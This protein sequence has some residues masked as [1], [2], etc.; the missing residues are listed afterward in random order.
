VGREDNRARRTVDAH[1]HAQDVQGVPRGD[2]C[3][4]AAEVI[5]EPTSR[6]FDAVSDS[7]ADIESQHDSSVSVPRESGGSVSNE[8]TAARNADAAD[9]PNA[10]HNAPGADPSRSVEDSPG[11]DDTHIAE[12]ARRNAD[13]GGGIGSLTNLADRHLGDFRLLRRIGHGGMAEVYLAEQVSLKRNVAVKVL[14][15]EMLADAVHVKRFEQEAKAAGGLNHPNIVQVYT[16]GK[17]GGIHYIAQEYVQGM[18]LREYLNRN[19][20]PDLE[21]ALSFMRQMTSALEAASEAGIVHRDIKPENILI[22][23]KDDVKITDFGLAQLTLPGER[24]NLTQVGMTMGTPLYMSPEQV[25]GRHVD[26]RSDLYS[27]GVTCYHMLCGI[28]PFRGET[29]LSVAVQHVNSEPPPLNTQRADLPEVVCRLVHRMMAKAPDDRYQTADALGIDLSRIAETLQQNP[30]ALSKLRL[31][32]A[33]LPSR[34]ARWM[35]PF[36]YWT[37]RQHMAAFAVCTLFIAGLAAAVGWRHR[38]PSP[39]KTPPAQPTQSVPRFDNARDQMAHAF[40]VDD[41]AAWKAVINNFRNDSSADWYRRRAKE[42]LAS[43]YLRTNRYEEAEEIYREF[44]L[45]DD[46]DLS[47]KATGYAGLVVIRSLQG[48]YEESNRLCADKLLPLLLP[49]MRDGKLDRSD[50]LFD[51]VRKAVTHNNR[52]LKNGQSQIDFGT[53]MQEQNGNTTK[54]EDD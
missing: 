45:E 23:R 7:K 13:S 22:T 28:T 34:F 24:L 41:E 37:P 12:G 16:I 46:K 36:F 49:L 40:L 4:S 33:K 35:A 39:F 10:P 6:E 54:T 26:H 17:A 42:E 32:E 9:V 11:A 27:L 31:A 44:T 20:P 19:G 25:N 53:L 52:Q 38:S 18:N 47:L 51:L 3:L 50:E 14:R 2:S 21:T 43:L 8:N 15:E 29:A 5:R 30:A 48:Q 1:G